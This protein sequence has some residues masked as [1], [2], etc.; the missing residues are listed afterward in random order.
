MQFSYIA[1][2]F[3]TL[4][5]TTAALPQTAE[6]ECWSD[7]SLN[8]VHAGNLR[9]GLCSTDGT[10]T[11]LKKSEAAPAPNPQV[12]CWPTCSYDCVQGEIFREISAPLMELALTCKI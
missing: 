7:C 10:C 1:G 12:D 6:L 4:V 11:C 5:T 2:A 3:L 9:G 8:C